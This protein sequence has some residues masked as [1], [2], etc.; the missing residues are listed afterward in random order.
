MDWIMAFS[1]S[2][3]R[4]SSSLAAIISC[5]SSSVFVFAAQKAAQYLKYPGL[6]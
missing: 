5:N 3:M 1:S 6:F 2:F 4:P